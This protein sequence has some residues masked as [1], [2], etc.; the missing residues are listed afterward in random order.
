M[1]TICTTHFNILELRILPTECVL[2]VSYDS[3]NKQLF[4]LNSIN[5]L[6]F[7]ADT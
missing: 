5:Q 4:F 6:V 3:H 7:V 2:C 1:V